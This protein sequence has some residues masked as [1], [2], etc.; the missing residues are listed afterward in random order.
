MVSGRKIA[1]TIILVFVGIAFFGLGL[2]SKTSSDNQV[3]AYSCQFT[4]SDKCPIMPLSIIA[5]FLFLTNFYWIFM[6]ISTLLIGFAIGRLF[7]G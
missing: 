3:K 7:G 4:C 6:M 2:I 1:V 5:P